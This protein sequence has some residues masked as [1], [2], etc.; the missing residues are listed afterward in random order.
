M[1]TGVLHTM[2][3]PNPITLTPHA[4]GWALAWPISYSDIMRTTAAFWLG[5]ERQ[6]TTAPQR[7]HTAASS[8]S[9][10][11]PPLPPSTWSRVPPSMTSSPC[12]RALCDAPS[13]RPDS[14][15]TQ[16]TYHLL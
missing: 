1:R 5:D 12:G 3:R 10:L 7:A 16:K 8:A 2:R 15:T 14:L 13:A 4:I 6:M 11:L 9:R